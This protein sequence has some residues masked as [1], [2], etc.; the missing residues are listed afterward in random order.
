MACD[1][2]T[3]VANSQC[4]ACEIP[5]G[6]TGYVALALM[7]RILNG[8]SMAC[9]IDTLMEEAKCL[10]CTVPQGMLGYLQL[11]VLCNI[12]A[13]QGGDVTVE[14]VLSIGEQCVTPVSWQFDPTET[15]PGRFPFEQ[16]RCVA[17][18]APS[19]MRLQ[20]QGTTGDVNGAAVTSDNLVRYD[21]IGWDGTGFFPG[22][23]WQAT[24]SEN[25]TT[26]AHG[27][28]M[29]C[30]VVANGATATTEALRITATQV[31]AR[32][33]AFFAVAGTQV[34][35]ARNTGWTT[36]TGTANKNA[37]A[38]DTGTVTTAQLAQVVKSLFDAL[39]T[40]GLIGT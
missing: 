33:G 4:M 27:T 7:C 37:G 8:E 9:D 13:L 21:F 20:K 40:H 12:S 38:L 15:V 28:R 32:N 1:V 24:A 2:P 39:V 25:W 31:D 36:F 35:S 17:D 14:G 34:V 23:T 16:T 29:T 26:V 22:G 18:S 10:Q 19:I 30:N 5:Q 6:L 11:A 3:L